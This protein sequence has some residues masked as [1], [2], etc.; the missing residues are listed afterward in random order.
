MTPAK[1]TPELTT[2]DGHK[3]WS[4]A[5]CGRS[6]PV[7]GQALSRCGYRHR[8]CRQSRYCPEDE[9]V[10]QANNLPRRTCRLR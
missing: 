5:F 1:F 3:L 9:P 10:P 7:E 6:C 2:D 8:N 4:S